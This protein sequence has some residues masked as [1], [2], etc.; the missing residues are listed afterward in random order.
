M[1]AAA[2][3]NATR[4]PAVHRVHGEADAEQLGEL[5]RPVHTATRA[6]AC[7]Y[8]HRGRIVHDGVDAAQLVERHQPNPKQHRAPQ[9]AF[10]PQPPQPRP[11]VLP[12]TQGRRRRRLVA[13]GR[14]LSLG[15][16]AVAADAAHY[17]LR[18]V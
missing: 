17:R 15:L 16:R 1:T 5:G 10:R 3:R 18:F 6:E 4:R 2:E 14:D 13:N 11:E 12:A 9:L 8:Q 7:A